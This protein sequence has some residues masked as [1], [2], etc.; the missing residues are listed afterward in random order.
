MPRSRQ[1]IIDAHN[2]VT[3]RLAAAASGLS[4]EDFARTVY[5]GWPVKDVLCHLASGSAAGAFF[6]A[7]ARS[8]RQ[9]PDAGFDLDRW[10]Q[11]RVAERRSKPVR[12]LVAEF[13]AGH[14]A[15]IK[16]LHEASDDLLAQ[17]VQSDVGVTLLADMLYITAAEHDAG[18]LDD[19]ERALGRHGEA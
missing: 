9:G 3:E 15:S 10:N 2:A 8:G 16:A 14:E 5:E 4:E 17:E 1:E 7:I 18:H 12:D 11:D 19:L 13:R 6:I